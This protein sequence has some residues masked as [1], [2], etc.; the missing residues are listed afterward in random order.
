MGVSI[1]D[2]KKL[3]E[4]TEATKVFTRDEFSKL[5]LTCHNV[6]R[7]N[8]SLDP[9]EAFDEI[10]KILFIKIRYERSKSKQKFS[11]D[12]FNDLKKGYLETVSK[13]AKPFYQNLFDQTKE[14]F[15]KDQLFEPNEQ[16]KINDDQFDGCKMFQ[17]PV[18]CNRAGRSSVRSS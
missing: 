10:S 18:P 13:N 14:D 8:D 17:Q 1:D 2:I 7:N 5:L 4:L 3:K 9:A 16:I 11:K 6:I 15:E 12:K